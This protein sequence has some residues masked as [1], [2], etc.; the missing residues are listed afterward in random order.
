MSP[1]GRAALPVAVDALGGDH[2]P[3]VVVAGAIEAARAGVSVLLVGEAERLRPLV[4]DVPGIEVVD[5]PDAI[6]MHELATVVH[7]RPRSSLVVA[8]E[9]VASG[10]AAAAVSCGHSGALVLGSVLELRL[11]EG[12]DRPA[13]AALLPRRD[14]GR[15]ILVDAGANV[16]TRPDHLVT[17]ARLGIALARSLGSARPSVGVLSNGSEPSKGDE[18]V[19]AGRDAVS[20]ALGRAIPFVEPPDALAGTVDVLVCDGF[21]GNVLLKGLEAA[22]EMALGVVA[23]HV[24][25]PDSAVDPLSW[26][27]RGGALLL[28]VRGVVVVGHG[29]ADPT[30]VRNAIVLARDAAAARLVERVRAAGASWGST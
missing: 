23:A 5:G 10:R 17:F 28:G 26:R 4:S 27:A 15:L 20:Q 14:G 3:D 22:V 1:P 25:L 11:V 21:V 30:A 2:A 16:D 13:I 19:R 6:A 8:L 18:R 12:I 7:G 9:L 24:D 29:R